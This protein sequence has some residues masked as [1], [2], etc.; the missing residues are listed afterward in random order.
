MQ[1][2]PLRNILMMLTCIVLLAQVGC[3]GGSSGSSGSGDS[4]HKLGG[5]LA[6][7]SAGQS[8]SLEDNGGD[9]L[10]LSANGTF[11][12]PMSLGA[13]SAYAITVKSHTPGI[14]CS[15]SN[16]SGTVGSSDLTGI[17]VSCSAGTAR[18]L[19]SLGANETDRV[20]PYAG[21]IT[22]GAGNIYGTTQNGGA[23][24]V[25]T[26]F[27]ISAAGAETILHS[28]GSSATDGWTPRADLIIDNAGNLYGT[29]VNGGA[30]QGGTVF[31]IDAAGTETIVYSFG[32]H[33][34]D[35]RYP[36]GGVIMDSSGNLYGMTSSG[37]S[38]GDG[39]VYKIEPA[40][41]ETILYSF[42]GSNIDGAAPYGSL[43]MDSAGNLYGTTS[44]G[45]AY[46]EGT[47]FKL[48]AAG[49]ETI[50]HSFGPKITDA[51]APAGGLIMDS[52][53]NLYGT[54]TQGGANVSGTVFKIDTA[55]AETILYSF[56]ASANDARSP[57]AYTKLIM[58]SAGSLYGTT[59]NGGAN[60]QNTFGDGTVFKISAN[61]KVT[62]LHSFGS[63]A[64][65]GLAPYSGLT[66]D[67]VG[68]LYGTTVSGGTNFGT[69][70]NGYLNDGGTVFVID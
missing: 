15:V 18:I 57:S 38:G 26:V 6:G 44:Q 40:G 25:G 23:N 64:S 70:Q 9:K 37:G 68:N 47:V 4:T 10:T 27:K 29:T 56:A 59:A 20:A 55:G 32:E 69:V 28:F 34:T 43:I 36:Y 50:L 65:D 51:R 14:A 7:L 58:D 39:T 61:G 22:D 3:G 17:G 5:T 35:G 45:G 60:H 11:S 21:V 52:A 31:K 63:S 19:H 13:G 33:V 62:I 24:G 42:S 46:F 1:E 54:T 12:F 66:V 49:A 2:N 30:N 53:G 48:S 41:T 8:V 16:G 67:S